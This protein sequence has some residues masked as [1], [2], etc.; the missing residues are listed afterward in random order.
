MS[1]MSLLSTLCPNVHMFY[2]SYVLPVIK[3]NDLEGQ[4]LQ[5]R[6]WLLYQMYIFLI[7]IFLEKS[8][9]PNMALSTLIPCVIYPVYSNL[10]ATDTHISVTSPVLSHV[11]R[12]SYSAP[13]FRFYSDVLITPQL[14]PWAFTQ[15]G[16]SPKFA[17]VTIFS[18]LFNGNSTCSFT[19]AN[20]LGVI[21]DSSSYSISNL[22]R[23]PVG[24]TFRR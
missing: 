6:H 10:H 20:N 19:Q 12:L 2:G 5:T 22:S 23:N 17:P 9:H 3:E 8:V 7:S 24:F 4:L 13:Y 15:I 18:I 16:L 21:F 14:I 1:S 11:L